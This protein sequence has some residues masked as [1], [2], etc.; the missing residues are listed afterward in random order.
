LARGAS[1]TPDYVVEEKLSDDIEIRKYVAGK[2]ACTTTNGQTIMFDQLF[3]YISGKRKRN[4]T[5]KNGRKKLK[6][7]LL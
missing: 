5:L 1:E 6:I 4:S 3:K 7:Y 2:W